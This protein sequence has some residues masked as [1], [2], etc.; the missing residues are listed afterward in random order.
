MDG[1]DNEPQMHADTRRWEVNSITEKIIGCAYKVG[2]GLGCG[3]V[4]KVYE[5]ALVHELRKSGLFVEQQYEMEVYYDGVVVG[6][7]FA[8][9]LVERKILVELKAVRAFE[10]RHFAQCLNYLKATNLTICLLI[11]FGNSKVEIKRVARN[12]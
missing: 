6:H 2:N 8:D 1:F 10:P 7:F 11:N 9:I 4:E 12:F 3:F 5:N